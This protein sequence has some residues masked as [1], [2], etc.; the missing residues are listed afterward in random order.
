MLKRFYLQAT[1]M[2]ECLINLRD[3]ATPF[4]DVDYTTVNLEIF[5]VKNFL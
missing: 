5:I 2:R 3:E 4:Y 1:G